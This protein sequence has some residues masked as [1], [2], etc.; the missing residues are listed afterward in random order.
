MSF[1]AC[2]QL[3]KLCIVGAMGRDDGGL[4]DGFATTN[5]AAG[6]AACWDRRRAGVG[7]VGDE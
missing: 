2:E 5:S 1:R 4:C 3:L 7:E 6:G